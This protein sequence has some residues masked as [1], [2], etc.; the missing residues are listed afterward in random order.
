MDQNG[1]EPQGA[2]CQW[3]KIRG[4]MLQGPAL[5]SKSSEGNGFNCGLGDKSTHAQADTGSSPHGTC[6]SNHADTVKGRHCARFYWVTS[7]SGVTPSLSRSIAYPRTHLLIFN[8]VKTEE[9]YGLHKQI[10]V[11]RQEGL[12]E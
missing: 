7:D 9:S 2:Q 6:R 12:R 8:R 10:P 5:T 11:Y 4:C 1:Q 3:F